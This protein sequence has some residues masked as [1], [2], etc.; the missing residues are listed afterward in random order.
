MSFYGDWLFHNMSIP[1]DLISLVDSASLRSSVCFIILRSGYPPLWIC[2]LLAVIIRVWLVARTHGVI[3]G[4][5]VLVGVQAEHILRGELPIYFYG[6][7]YMGSLEAYL[8]A[9]LIAIAG[10]SAWTLRG[11]PILLS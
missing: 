10:P 4:D 9:I 6:Q 5:E 11:E 8:V 2:L 3:D 1:Q 7:P